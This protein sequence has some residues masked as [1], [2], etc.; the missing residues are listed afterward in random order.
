MSEKCDKC[1]E[2]FSDE[3]CKCGF[4]L[5]RLLV[6]E[7]FDFDAALRQLCYAVRQAKVKRWYR[8]TAESEARRISA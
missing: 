6:H 5:V 2:T 4:L 1:G 8:L 3:L 7:A